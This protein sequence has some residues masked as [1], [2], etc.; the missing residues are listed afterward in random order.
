MRSIEETNEVKMNKAIYIH[1]PFCA[2][3]CYYC[4]FTSYVGRDEEID[5]YLDSLNGLVHG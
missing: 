1:I 3:K 4:D 2:K 5:S